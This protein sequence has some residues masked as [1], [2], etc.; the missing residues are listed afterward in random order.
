MQKITIF[1]PHSDASPVIT[2]ELQPFLRNGT[3]FES[4]VIVD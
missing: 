3:S 2:H 1:R 4:H